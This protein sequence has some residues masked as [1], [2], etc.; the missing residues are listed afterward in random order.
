MRRRARRNVRGSGYSFRHI[1]TLGIETEN[2]AF[3]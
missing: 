1:Q 2:P 3:S